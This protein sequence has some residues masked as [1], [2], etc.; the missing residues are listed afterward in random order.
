MKRTTVK[1]AVTTALLLSSSSVFATNG[2]VLIGTGTKIRGMAGTGIGIGHGAESAL[3]NPAFITSVKNID[4]SFG[5]TLFMPNVKNKNN[6]VVPAGNPG[7]GTVY[8]TGF[9]NSTADKGVIP[10]ISI[11]TKINEHFYVGLGMWGT[12]GMGVDYRDTKGPLEGG[13]QFKMVTNLQ[14]MQF[15]APLAYKTHGLSLAVTP[16]LQYGSLDMNYVSTNSAGNEEKSNGAGVG[17]DLKFG[18]NIGLSYERSGFTIG[19]VYKSQINM[20]YKDQLKSA[21]A[22]FGVE[23]KNTQLSTP[24]EY[25]VGVSYRLGA[26]SFA[27]DCKKIKWSTAK[28]YKDFKWNDQNVFALGYKYTT[29]KWIARFGYNYGKS[30][31]K[32][33]ALGSMGSIVPGHPEQGDKA[34]LINTL[35]L[36]GFPGIVKSH[37]SLGGTYAL[38]EVVSV[39]LAYIYAPEVSATYKNF[40][41]QDITTKHSQQSVSFQMTY[42][43]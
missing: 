25:G 4:I 33:Q 39:D 32:E 2:S 10:E 16:I 1:I 37:Y 5:G 24:S 18:Y 7:A 26:S 27:I 31:V 8:N 3:S 15:G 20:D 43:F 41:G 14:L 22:G 29:E 40:A 34:G 30:P 21:M 35:N 9:E 12:A 6:L 23:Y 17:Q 19:A 36:L 28:G 38:N 13:T 11:A 42:D